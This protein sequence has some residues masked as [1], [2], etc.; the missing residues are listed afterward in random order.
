MQ[1]IKFIFF[2]TQVLFL[3]E[4]QTRFKVNYSFLT[5]EKACLFFCAGNKVTASGYRLKKEITRFYKSLACWNPIST[6]NGLPTAPQ[7]KRW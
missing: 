4:E 5:S 3:P 2:S 1:C 6:S 7:C